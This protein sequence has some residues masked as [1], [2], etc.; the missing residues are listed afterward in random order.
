MHAMSAAPLQLNDPCI[1]FA[2]RR[3]RHPFHKEFPPNQR[4]PG[5]PCWARFCGPAWLS[6]LVLETGM[7]P[8][9]VRPAV[10]WLLAQPTLD[11]L[12]YVPKMLLFAGYA[13]ALSDDLHVGDLVLATEIVTAD[14]QRWPTTWPGELPP[15]RWR[16][17]LRR[18]AVASVAHMIS[19][20]ADKRRL[21]DEHGALAVDMES[22]EFARLCSQ[23]EMPFGVLRA[24]SDEA[25]TPLS[26][27]LTRLLV[28]GRV[29]WWQTLRTI[30]RRP[31]IVKELLRLGRHTKMASQQ[32]ALGLGELLTLTLPW[33]L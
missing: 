16:P 25:D 28:G 7:G 4:F 8:K 19:Q 17:P 15:G 2:L 33:D 20:P 29:S 12:P 6:V 10:E 24:I 26:P 18:G 27:E 22:A 13:G 5:A 3:E 32:L 9:C 31:S 1:L 23:R 11:Q 30:V 21:Y 14:G